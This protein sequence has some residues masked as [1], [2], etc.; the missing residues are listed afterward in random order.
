[1]TGYVMVV[2][3]FVVGEVVMLVIG[4]NDGAMVVFIFMVGDVSMLVTAVID[5]VMVLFIFVV[6]DVVMIFDRRD[7]WCHGGVCLR[8][9]RRAE[10]CERRR[11]AL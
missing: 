3:V 7:R 6:G 4:V 8:D 11:E 5:S 2:F 9:R 10:A 1:V